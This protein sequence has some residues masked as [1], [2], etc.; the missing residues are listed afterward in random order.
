MAKS[1]MLSNGREFL[2][3]TAALAHFK[4]I[5]HAYKSGDEI[6][7]PGHHSDLSA[8]L[9][10]YDASITQDPPKIGSGINRFERRQ[11]KGPGYSTPGFWVERT[12]GSW[13]DFS[14]I[15]GVK[16]RPKPR[17]QEFSDACRHTVNGD[18]QAAKRRHFEQFANAD[19]KVLCDLTDQPITFD[20]AHLDHAYPTFGIIVSM[21][22]AA[23]GWHDEIPDGV[24]SIAQ[25][26]QTTTTFIDP[27]IA[28]SFREVHHRGA[29]MR[30]ISAQKN[31]SMAPQQRVP[32]IKRPVQLPL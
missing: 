14:Y 16:A 27:A 12:D 24:L 21:F 22:R 7:D 5:L 28:E 8:L 26:N 3:E 13:T 20:E 17:S 25:D 31:L 10:R 4:A 9:V 18:I 32:V 2:S 11:N 15:T 6:T 30:M 1:V 29:K 23:R 19:G